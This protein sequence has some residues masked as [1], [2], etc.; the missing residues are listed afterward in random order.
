MQKPQH[1][2]FDL[3]YDLKMSMKMGYL[4]PVH[5]QEV[6]PGDVFTQSCEAMFRLMPMTAPIMH[7]VEF[8][9]HHFYVA[10]RLVWPNW[11]DFIFGG[12]SI[13]TVPH[14]VPTI[15][16]GDVHPSSLLDYMGVPPDAGVDKTLTEISALP[17]AAYHMIWYEW[18]RDQNL[19]V[20]DPVILVDGAQA[21]PEELKLKELKKR[22]WEHDYFTSALPFAQKGVP[23]ELP[24]DT[25]SLI[26]DAP[27]TGIAGVNQPVVRRSTDGAPLAGGIGGAGTT[28]KLDRTSDGQEVYIDPMGAYTITGSAGATINDLR[29]AMALQRW[30]ELNARAGTRPWEALKAHFN[31]RSKDSRLQRPE[32]LGGS[33]GSMAI[34]EVLQT[35]SSDVTSPQGG[36]AGHGIGINAGNG[37]RYQCPEHGYIISILSIVPRTAYYNGLPKHFSKTDRYQY[38]W[39]LLAN[40]GEQAILNQEL[41]LTGNPAADEATFGYIPIYSEYR[42]NNS[43]VAGQMVT[44]LEHWHMGRKFDMTASVALNADFIKCDPT[45]RI[46]AVIDPDEDKIIG[47]IFHKI[48]ARRPIPVYG[49]PG[50]V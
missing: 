2:M 7:K 22:A 40:L 24:F 36:M 5:V 29:T 46:F 21:G 9:F 27:A 34:S 45:D 3:S 38:Y 47:H 48:M 35:S 30:L 11:D 42:F 49:A 14:A 32:Y 6:L 31:M 23:V 44:S 28:G 17:F 25:G 26:V 16:V 18:Y 20:E 1:S 10:N 12:E 37:F 43:R 13:G 39:P 41:V 8:S 4:V 33:K 15:K 50:G 19:Q